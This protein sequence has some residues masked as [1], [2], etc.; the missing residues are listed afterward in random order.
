[1]CVCTDDVRVYYVQHVRQWW[2]DRAT[3]L[4]LLSGGGG[5]VLGVSA[6][7]RGDDGD[8]FR[9]EEAERESDGRP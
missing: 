7:V 1:M 8:Q 3:E 6:R 9:S 5:G 4:T 2:V